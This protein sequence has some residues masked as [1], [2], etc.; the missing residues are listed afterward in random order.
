MPKNGEQALRAYLALVPKAAKE[1][2]DYAML[3]VEREAKQN[4]PYTDQTGNLTNS[5]IAGV[6]TATS[7]QVVGGLGAG[8]YYAP[9]VELGTSKA[10]PYPFI[11]PALQ[12]MIAQKIFDRAFSSLLQ[13]KGGGT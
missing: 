9:F 3:W 12:K 1:A 6:T 10:P 13:S 11:R 8:M 4:H 5:I 2:M 7:D